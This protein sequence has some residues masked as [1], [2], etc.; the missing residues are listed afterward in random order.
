MAYGGFTN[1]PGLCLYT[2]DGMPS[3]G[4]GWKLGQDKFG[5]PVWI[6]PTTWTKCCGCLPPEAEDD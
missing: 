6:E 4:E 2:C 3:P 1:K 5:C